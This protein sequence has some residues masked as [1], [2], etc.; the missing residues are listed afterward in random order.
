[1]KV[2]SGDELGQKP[3]LAPGAGSEFEAI[4]DP[5]PMGLKAQEFLMALRVAHVKSAL[6][7]DVKIA[8]CKYRSAAYCGDR[9]AFSGERRPTTPQVKNTCRPATAVFG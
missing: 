9:E 4:R 6:S 5:K 1:M 2:T 8:G 3:L 7:K